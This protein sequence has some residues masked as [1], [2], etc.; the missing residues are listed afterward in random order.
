[1][2]A[3]TCPIQR[4]IGDGQ[5]EWIMKHP[6]FVGMGDGIAFGQILPAL[7]KY[8]VHFYEG[9]ARLFRF[10]KSRVFTHRAYIDGAG[11]GEREVGKAESTTLTLVDIR[12]RAVCHRPD[13]SE[14]VGVHKLFTHFAVTR[15]PYRP[16]ELAL[17]DVEARFAANSEDTPELPP[18]MIDLA[19]LLP[20]RRL[21]FVE[22]KCVGN[23]AVRSEGTA[24]VVTQVRDYERHIMREGVLDALNRSLKVQSCL[25]GRDLGQSEGVFPKVPVLVLDP[26]KR[27][28]SHRSTDTWLRSA[29][30]RSGHPEADSLSIN[31]IDG[32]STPP[33]YAIS[34]FVAG[35]R[36]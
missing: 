31:V 14:L 18:G 9:G 28:I 32:I 27:G 30:A 33:D 6:F 20:D 25:V 2:P 15:R 34:Q 10:T 17:I 21:L 23:S 19:F 24:K 22:A 29:L 16:G 4:A 3:V 5:L 35:L 1:L 36:I 12:R 13:N 11:D 8:E 26:T 7:R